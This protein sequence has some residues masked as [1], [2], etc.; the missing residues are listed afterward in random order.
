MGVS[1]L[2]EKQ[3]Q[4]Q[5]D[6]LKQIREDSLLVKRLADNMAECATNIHGQGYSAFLDARET[7]LSE[8][9]KLYEEYCF[10]IGAERPK[11]C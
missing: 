7:F 1:E 2:K 10:F 11:C 3:L 8:L 4:L 5:K 9:D 6:M